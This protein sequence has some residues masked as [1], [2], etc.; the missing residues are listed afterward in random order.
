MINVWGTRFNLCTG[1][2]LGLQSL[3]DTAQTYH[4]YVSHK[5]M[6]HVHI[7]LLSQREE[8]I[9]MHAAYCFFCFL[10]IVPLKT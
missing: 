7:Y 10:Q 8:L 1:N 3:M 2:I 5:H 9:Y 4:M 6:R